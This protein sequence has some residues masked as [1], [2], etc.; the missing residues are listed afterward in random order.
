MYK[1]E[2]IAHDLEIGILVAEAGCILESLS[3][4][5]GSQSDSPDAHIMPLDFGSKGR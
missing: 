4:Y 3:E 5:V 1:C 2:S